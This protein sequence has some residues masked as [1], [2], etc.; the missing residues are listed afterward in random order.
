MRRLA[1]LNL[2]QRIVVVVALAV[3][4]HTVWTYLVWRPAGGGWYSYAPLSRETYAPLSAHTYYGASGS[5]VVRALVAI[6]LIVVWAWASI[7]L[8]GL[9]QP[10]SG[11]Q[12]DSS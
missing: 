10:H 4:F 8:L 11:G 6:A 5:G 7:W 12:P 1:A 9:S 2:A 3:G